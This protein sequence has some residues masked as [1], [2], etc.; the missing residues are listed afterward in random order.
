MT[1]SNSEYP[2]INLSDDVVALTAALVD[3]PSE[4]KHERLIAD[5]VEAALRGCPHLGVHRRGNTIVA[6]T[7]LGRNERV[8]IGGHLDTVPASDNLGHRLVDGRLYGLGACDMKGGVAV[9]LKLAHELRD[10][11]RDVTYVFYECEEIEGK[12]NGLAHLAAAEPRWLAA[13]FAILMEPSN[14]GVEAGCQGTMRVE[15]RTQGRR[16]HSARSWLG[17]NAIHK[18]GEILTRLSNYSAQVVQID[19]LAYREGMSAVRIAGGHAGNVI[20]DEAAVTVNYRFAPSVSP[21]QAEVHIRELFEGFDVKVVDIAAG[22]LPGLTHPAAASFVE[23][24]GSKPQ[25][26]LGWTDVARFSALGVPAINFGPGDPNLAHTAS[27]YVPIDQLHSCE[28]VLR[29]W[30]T[31]G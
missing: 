6:R 7:E 10:P 11:V 25:P 12:F 24:V 2:G 1:A 28:A 5:R 18:A 23:A 19:G 15:V 21:E 31:G 14:A 9:G 27:E 3:I 22:A 17:E 8:V 29:C 13:D 4:S 26:K 20:P 30:L 16:A